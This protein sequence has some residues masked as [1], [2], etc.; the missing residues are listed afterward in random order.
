MIQSQNWL[1]SVVT[2]IFTCVHKPQ[3]ELSF[4]I[5]ASC[6]LRKKN[7]YPGIGEFL[8]WDVQNGWETTSLQPI[9]WV[10]VWGQLYL[11]QTF[12]SHTLT[13]TLP[14]PVMKQSTFPK[15]VSTASVTC[16]L[17]FTAQVVNG[18]IWAEPDQVTRVAQSPEAYLQNHPQAWLTLTQC[19][20]VHL[21][22][23]YL[24]KGHLGSLCIWLLPSELLSQGKSTGNIKHTETVL[25]FT[26][27]HSLLHSIHKEHK[28][29]W[30]C[31][32]EILPC[33]TAGS[34]VWSVPV[35]NPKWLVQIHRDSWHP[36]SWHHKLSSHV[37]LPLFYF[38]TEVLRTDSALLDYISVLCQL[39]IA[40]L[41]NLHNQNLWPEGC[42]FESW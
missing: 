12:P 11:V 42:Q 24:S 33:L 15:P 18:S 23:L 10:D 3:L 7:S 5:T 16:L 20:Q 40:K 30:I 37:A 6:S 29:A 32:V 21:V 35:Y 26:K 22:Y 27:I 9:L 34:V 36:I 25:Q 4:L 31:K 19:R 17:P 8:L 41:Q 2:T 38:Y 13:R 14:L 39:Y 1:S 28:Y